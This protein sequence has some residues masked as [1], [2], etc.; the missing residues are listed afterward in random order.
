MFKHHRQHY[1]EWFFSLMLE[2]I[3]QKK[4]VALLRQTG[5]CGPTDS[6]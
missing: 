2:P 4:A 3:M 5:V 6:N 1:S